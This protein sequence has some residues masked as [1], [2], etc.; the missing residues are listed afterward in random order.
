MELNWREYIESNPKVLFGKPVIK[1]TR[2]SV[3]LILEKLSKGESFDQ[4]LKAYPHINQNSIFACLSF[5]AEAI[6]NEIVIPKAS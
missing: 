2:I 3:D 5:A 4:L 1:G 6:K